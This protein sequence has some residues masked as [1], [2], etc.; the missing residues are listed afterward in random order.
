MIGF[1]NDRPIAVLLVVLLA[2]E[3]LAAT[4]ITTNSVVIDEFAHLPAGVA[5]WQRGM[6]SMY[7]ENP[8]LAR[9]LVAIPATLFGA[10][11]DYAKAGIERRWEWDVALDFRMANRAHYLSMFAWGRFVVVGLAVT[12]GMLIF[13]W[14]GRQYG[15]A[16]ALICATLWFAD[17]NVLAHSTIATTDIA[18]TAFGLLATYW[19]W[20][21]LRHPSGSSACLA[22]LGLGLA[23]GTKF[24]M[25][26]LI[27]A[28]AAMAFITAWSHQDYRAGSRWQTVARAVTIPAV[29][30]LTLN[31]L[32]GFRGTLT[33]LKSLTF[34]SPLLSGSPAISSGDFVGNR[35]QGTLLGNLLVPLPVDFLIGFDS[36]LDDHQVGRFANIS[37]GHLVAGGFWYSPLQAL[38]FKLPGGSFLLLIVAI[39]YWIGDLR[40]T[41][42]NEGLVWI[43]PLTLIV[44]LCTQ[45]GGLNFAYRYT[46]PALP[47]ILI[48]AGKLVEGVWKHRLGRVFVAIC[49]LW[50]GVAVLTIHPSYL[51]FGNEL[52]GGPA[53]AQRMFLGSNFDWGQDLFRLKRWAD[54]HPRLRP[55]AVAYYGPIVPTE[56]G[57]ETCPLPDSLFQNPNE[58]SEEGPREGFYLA[59][60]SNGLH[61]LPCHIVG[62]LDSYKVGIIRSKLLR[63]EN[64]VARV[65]HSI[66][67]FRVEPRSE[68]PEDHRLTVDK[69][70][71]CIKEIRPEDF[72]DT[73]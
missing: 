20:G 12:C 51:S 33:P 47:F 48:A 36:Q 1:L 15:T 59:I 38:F 37:G 21:F 34:T 32:Y 4:A 73:P 65:G 53:G 11:M 43:P 42:A 69:L 30:L 6:F 72:T 66:Y 63:P 24:T 27:P 26:L 40:R 70:V 44:F 3:L 31:L 52:A 7:D 5:Y 62:D 19:Y 28:W 14:A 57:L 10:R 50:N 2:F 55:L 35:F 67:V 64:A 18:A 41:R 25:L 23:V 54:A 13:R 17:P 56:I 71:A 9:Y 61:G 46:L 16:A 29:A 8:P 22:G 68:S 49:L 58:V 45:A 60:S 39:G